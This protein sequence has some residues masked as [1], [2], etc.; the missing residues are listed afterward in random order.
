MTDKKFVLVANIRTEDRIVV[1]RVLSQLVGVDAI[2][3]TDDGFRVRTTMEGR[4]AREMNQ[5]AYPRS[6]VP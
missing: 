1:E 5:R 6:E 3:Q 2:L 4:S